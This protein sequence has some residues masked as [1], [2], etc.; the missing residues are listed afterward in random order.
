MP[1][2]GPPDR[3]AAPACREGSRRGR[4]RPRRR[5]R[6][7]PVT[8]HPGD[9]ST[10]TGDIIG[11][12]AAEPGSV[13][14]F[15]SG[16][17]APR[18]CWASRVTGW[19]WPAWR[20]AAVRRAAAGTRR[21]GRPRGGDGRPRR[22]TGAGGLVLSGVR[23][24]AVRPGRPVNSGGFTAG[25]FSGRVVRGRCGRLR[26]AGFPGWRGAG[27]AGRRR[28]GWRRRGGRGARRG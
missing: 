11:R 26:V 22:R 19:P 15:C 13:G 25:R 7:V 5:L 1:D 18:G 23:P 24:G 17:P 10:A 8:W 3:V 16:R 20:L 28:P 27:A 12:G 21:P 14:W 9:G 4:G 6:R 2:T